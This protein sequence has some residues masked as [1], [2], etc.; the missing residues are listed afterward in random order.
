MGA[1]GCT[2]PVRSTRV[3]YNPWHPKLSRRFCCG[4]PPSPIGVRSD[5]EGHQLVVPQLTL[6]PAADKVVTADDAKAADHVH[7]HRQREGVGGVDEQKNEARA[8]LELTVGKD[9]RTAERQ[10][11]N[12]RRTGRFVTRRSDLAGS[13]LSGRQTAKAAAVSPAAL[14]RY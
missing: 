1:T 12:P 2:Q 13:Q 7:I 10:V 8:R 11:V 9:A 4:R 14:A 5:H 3:E 6:E